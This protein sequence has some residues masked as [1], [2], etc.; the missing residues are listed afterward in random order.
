MHA[1]DTDLRTM[2]TGLDYRVE[3]DAFSYQSLWQDW[4]DNPVAVRYGAREHRR[5][6]WE[7][8]LA[9]LGVIVGEVAGR[10]VFLSLRRAKVN[11]SAVLFW[12]ATSVVVDHDLIEEWFLREAAG[13]PGTDAQNFIHAVDAGTERKGDAP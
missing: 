1:F 6:T 10:P 12:H 9:G 11:G 7:S 3:A 8:D 5:V 13:V 4:S 2:L